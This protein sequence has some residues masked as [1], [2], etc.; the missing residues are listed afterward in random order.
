MLEPH[1]APSGFRYRKKAESFVRRIPDGRQE[2]SLA[3]WGYKPSFEFS[4]SFSVRLEAAQAIT[5]QFSG[6][7]PKYYD[8]TTTSLT[9]L[10]FLGLPPN[11][12]GQVRWRV[13]SESDLIAVLPG[14]IEV[15]HQR[16]LPFFAEFQDLAALNRGLNPAGAENLLELSSDG[17]AFDASNMPYRAMAGVVVAHL[18][19]DDRLPDLIAAY[20]SQIRDLLESER[21]KFENLVAFV[22]QRDAT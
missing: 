17:S 21:Q 12:T 1:L 22:S 9:Q 2:L 7:L 10:E 14:V 3:L 5:N 16:I 8:I 19:A 18:V 4:F 20:R 11:D 6:A 13:V 15:V